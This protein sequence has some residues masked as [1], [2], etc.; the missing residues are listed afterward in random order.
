MDGFAVAQRAT[1]KN[2]RL[3]FTLIDRATPAPW[4]KLARR[5]VVFDRY[6]SSYLG[7]SLPNTLSLVA[8]DAYG[9]D[10]GSSADFASL[11][12]S[13]IPTVFDRANQ[14]GVSWK[15]YVGGL[16]QIARAQDRQR[17]VRTTRPRPRRAPCTGRRSCR[18]SG[19]GPIRRCRRTCGP[20]P[21]CSPTPRRGRC[22]RSRTCCRSRPR[23]SRRSSAPDLRLLSIVNALETSPDW[24]DDRGRGHL[25]RLGRLL[26]PRRAAGGERRAPARDARP[27]AAAVALGA[28]RN[29]LEPDARSLVD[30]GARD[31][32]VRA[33]PDHAAHGRVER[34]VARDAR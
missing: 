10:Q 11:W 1:D 32:A 26:R 4:R 19:S 7:G 13:D 16:E 20:R 30:P 33:G 18:C 21:T 15:Y 22:R 9:R 17:V 2:A 25:G 3:S 23:T 27:D 28:G 6:F 24:S 29:G 12:D 5:G 14:A 8:G 34:A 31:L